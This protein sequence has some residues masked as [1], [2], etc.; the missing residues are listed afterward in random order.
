MKNPRRAGCFVI[1]YRKKGSSPRP[2]CLRS[3]YLYSMPSSVTGAV[4][5]AFLG[6][7]SIPLDTGSGQTG[8]VVR[9]QLLLLRAQKIEVVPRENAR[10]MAIRK[11]GLHPVVADRLHAKQIHIPLATLQHLLTRT[12]ALH[13]R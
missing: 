12:V 2:Y 6:H 10:R 9:P 8:G 5:P 13:F 4:F 7:G 11:R 1:L 3:Y